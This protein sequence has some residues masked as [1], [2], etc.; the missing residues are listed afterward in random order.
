MCWNAEVSLNTFV[1][2]IFVLLFVYYNEKYTKYKI[3][4]FDNIWLYIFLLSAYLMQLIEYFLWT[5]IKTKYNR[6]FTIAVVLL[7][8]CQPVASLMLLTNIGLRNIMITLY[9][10][11]AVP[12]TAYII[13]YKKLRSV[14]S[15]GGNLN[16][17]IPAPWWLVWAWVFVFL[18]S[19]MYEQKWPCLL[20]A[21]ITFGVFIYKEMTSSPSMWCWVINIL[22]IYYASYILFYLPFCE[23]KSV[24]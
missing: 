16:W 8:F 20:F 21:I 22:S 4:G 18:F 2:S 12:Y 9:L 14:V 19:F 17:N 15:P 24:C 1:F 10:L 5:N 6:F 11:F 3:P 23:N 7:L 13:L